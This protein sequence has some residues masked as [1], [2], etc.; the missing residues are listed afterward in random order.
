[1]PVGVY[2]HKPHSEETKRKISE[3]CKGHIPWN[4]GKSM[5]DD[6]KKKL[7]GNTNGKGNRGMKHSKEARKK[8][9]EAL[10]GRK[11]SEEHKKNLSKSRNGHWN[12]IDEEK[13]CLICLKG[14]RV[15]R[16][17]E[18]ENQRF[19]S[20]KCYWIWLKDNSK[21]GEVNW[22]GGISIGENKKHYQKTKMY[23]NRALKKEALGTHT[24]TEW[25]ALKIK[26]KFMCLCCKKV[27]PEIKL[28][29]DHIIPLKKGGS[30]DIEN[31][32]PLCKSCNSRKWLYIID[33][34]DN[35]VQQIKK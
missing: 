9:S 25:L 23:E 19:C 16:K 20:Y 1:M 31:I 3:A 7:S 15:S 33:Y 28:T 10:T 21:I 35:K 26:Y 5:S 13:K 6:F 34:R 11:F 24:E 32:Q 27:E 12:N 22:K 30:N 18:L 4:K 14:F 17:R 29:E 8:I 2:K